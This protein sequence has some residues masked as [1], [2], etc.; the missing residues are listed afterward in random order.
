M[1]AAAAPTRSIQYSQVL[2]AFEVARSLGNKSDRLDVAVLDRSGRLLVQDTLDSYK[3]VA[4]FAELMRRLGFHEL[5]PRTAQRVC[6]CTVAFVASDTDE[7]LSV[8]PQEIFDL[9][10]WAEQAH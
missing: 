3:Q 9:D 8:L 1:P 4:M 5:L 10:S 2:R 7:C 6:E